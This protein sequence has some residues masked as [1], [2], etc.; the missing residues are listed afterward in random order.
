MLLDLDHDMFI[1]PSPGSSDAVL[2]HISHPSAPASDKATR[3]HASLLD[4]LG[5]APDLGSKPHVFLEVDNATFPC[6][7]GCCHVNASREGDMCFAGGGGQ[8]ASREGGRGSEEVIQLLVTACLILKTLVVL[9]LGPINIALLQLHLWQW[10]LQ[11]A[12][13]L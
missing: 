12:Q 13:R 1:A 4:G 9:F 8:E 3:L 10:Q 11:S 7:P 5:P 6:G 2:L